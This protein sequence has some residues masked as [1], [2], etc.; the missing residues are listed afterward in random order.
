MSNDP[1]VNMCNVKSHPM[2]IVHCSLL[3]EKSAILK[4]FISRPDSFI[5]KARVQEVPIDRK[6][7]VQ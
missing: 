3:I 6:V 2:I 7:T 4:K 5:L 1:V